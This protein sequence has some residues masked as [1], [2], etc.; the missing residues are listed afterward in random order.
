MRHANAKLILVLL[1]QTL[2]IALAQQRIVL[3]QA[4]SGTA[5]SSNQTHAPQHPPT[6][7]PSG[8]NPTVL[9]APRFHF[10]LAESA[11]PPTL[12][13][14]AQH[15][16]PMFIF[17]DDPPSP[18][19]ANS[20]TDIPQ[21]PTPPAKPTNPPPIVFPSG[22]PTS[23]G[24]R[25]E[26]R[27]TL[28]GVFTLNYSR[29]SDHATATGNEIANTALAQGND[30]GV[31][32]D[33]NLGTYLLDPRFL[34]FSLGTSFFWDKG[35][36]DQFGTRQTN[37]AITLYADFLPT[38]PYPLRLHY[39]KQNSNLLERQIASATTGR[40]SFGFDWSLRKPKWPA[41]ALSFD[42]TNYDT[43]FLASSEFKSKAR[44]LTATI[45]DNYFGW[46]L[47]ASYSNQAA[48]EG[49]TN[50][51]TRLNQGRVD[52]RRH[53]GNRSNVNFSLTAET[54]NF[55]SAPTNVNQQFSFLAFH[56]DFNFNLTDKL[57]ARASYQFYYNTNTD[58]SGP[59][60]SQTAGGPS[61]ASSNS[62][63]NF[64]SVRG[65]LT[66]HWL[67]EITL[68]GMVSERVFNAP[69]SSFESAA[70]YT[71]FSGTVTW[72]RRVGAV[73][74][75]ASFT[76]GLS[77]V[78]SNFG[79]SRRVEFHNYSA[80]LSVG[81]LKRVLI[82]ADFN[83]SRRPDV[84]QLGGFFSERFYEAGVET[85]ALR[86]FHVRMSVGAN[87]LDYLTSNGRENFNHTSFSL[88]VD[89]KP[90][91]FSLNHNGK[92]GVRD[93]FVVPV[94]LDHIFVV[95]PVDNLIR[96]PLLDTSG[97][98]TTGL[99]RYSPKP[100][101]D[102]EVRYLKDKLLFVRTN[103]VFIK[104]LDFLMSYRIGKITVQAGAIFY[105]QTIEGLF[106]RD[107]NYYFVRVSRP[108][109]LL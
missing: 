14:E 9:P 48:T 23:R 44:T 75:R 87:Q 12:I 30:L 77:S 69:E 43:R 56:T 105:R 37:T 97:Q 36:Y 99:L 18:V 94:P 85:Q 6:P 47:N 25:N 59:G 86:G 96:D 39:L 103:D 72:N 33:L 20:P 55:L 15:K 63:T 95:L 93:I 53:I 21:K 71:D 51:E 3:A 62:R 1:G 54:F 102:F 28:S 90:I 7:V 29:T 91:T 38:S 104:Q 40:D 50:L 5:E 34:K 57:T 42:T 26:K 41:V 82:T 70:R 83:A 10:E 80:G 35:A 16:S 64:N 81:T 74:T 67:P 88:S 13:S 89:K 98:S 79:N 22:I 61:L 19:P 46:D 76:Q 108:F 45:A 24:S 68:D 92:K 58:R 4:K 27:L 31:G 49:I 52:G 109:N 8:K 66:Y 32:L 78:N 100:N 11:A 17:N 73:N 65:E 2:I 60:F 101:L 107:R 84:F 106:S